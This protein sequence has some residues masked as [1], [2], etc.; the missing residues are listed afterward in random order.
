MDPSFLDM[1]FLKASVFVV[2]SESLCASC[3]DTC[4]SYMVILHTT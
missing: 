2:L 3:T 1:F 4:R